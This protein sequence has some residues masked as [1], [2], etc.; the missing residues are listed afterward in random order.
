MV[1]L[2]WRTLPLSSCHLKKTCSW[3]SD[4]CQVFPLVLNTQHQWF[5]SLTGDSF[6]YF[7]CKEV[8]GKKD[9]S[10][11]R[12]R[13]MKWNTLMCHSTSVTCISHFTYQLNVNGS[14]LGIWFLFLC[15][16]WGRSSTCSV[17]SCLDRVFLSSSQSLVPVNSIS[18]GQ[19]MRC[20]WVVVTVLLIHIVNYV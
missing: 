8:G 14:R 9:E 17:C 11:I 1:S 3:S 13:S 16:M 10:L 15:S 20:H 18:V 4:F 6:S 19:N 5:F 2:G 7:F 12:S